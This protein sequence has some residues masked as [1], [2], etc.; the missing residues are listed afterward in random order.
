MFRRK[1]ALN[2]LFKTGLSN[3][4]ENILITETKSAWID[5]DFIVKTK[6]IKRKFDK[7]D[8]YSKLPNII[9]NKYY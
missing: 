7:Y 9:E 5:G 8:L 1:G 4:C 2:I 3:W 6:F